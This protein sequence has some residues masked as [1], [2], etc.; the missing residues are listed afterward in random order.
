MQAFWAFTDGMGITQGAGLHCASAFVTCDNAK[1][2][3]RIKKVAFLRMLVIL[4]LKKFLS[5]EPAR[6]KLL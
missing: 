2:S 5:F 3:V 1:I 6:Y 4:L